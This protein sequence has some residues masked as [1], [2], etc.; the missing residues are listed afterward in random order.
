MSN[1][2]RPIIKCKNGRFAGYEKDGILIFKGI[3]YAKP[4]VGN[5]RWRPPQRPED[6]EELF[7]AV[8]FGASGYQTYCFSELASHN[9]LSEDCLTLNIW[10]GDIDKPKKP[11]MVWIHGG[12]FN[13]G[14]TSDPNYD[15]EF[16]VKEHQDVVLISTNYRIGLMG[17]LDFRGIPGGENYPEGPYLGILDLIQALKWIHENADSFGGDADNITI[18]G[19]SAGGGLVCTL[20]VCDGAEGLFKRVIAQSGTLNLLFPDEQFVKEAEEGRSVAQLLAAKVGAKTMDD[21]AALPAEELFAAYSAFDENLGMVL[22]DVYT[23]PLKGGSSPVPADPYKAL[24]EGK[25][26][27]IDFIIGTNA[28]EWRY[29]IFV[30]NDIDVSLLTEEERDKVLQEDLDMYGEY[31]EMLIDNFYD[32]STDEQKA[33]IDAALELQQENE[34]RKWKLTTILNEAL[35]RL[36]SIEAA[37]RHAKAGGKTYMYLFDKKST[38]YDWLG[39]CHACEIAYVFN[40]LSAEPWTGEMNP[41]LALDISTSWAN[42]A[43]TGDP[44]IEKAPWLPYDSQTRNTMLFGND[45]TMKMVQDPWKKQRELLDFAYRYVPAI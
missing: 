45:C 19:E 31:V 4:P 15:G 30:M 21:M 39:A 1:A 14:G 22:N 10:A 34:E 43:R 42:F 3:P 9:R 13:Y 38:A 44:G 36:P 7:D 28:D 6:S 17:F 37:E 41:K 33:R 20:M 5:L 18:F 16:F 27:D 32:A 2:D 12:G 35:F 40:H 26:K 8:E 23:M 11:I 29:F 25:G 24:A